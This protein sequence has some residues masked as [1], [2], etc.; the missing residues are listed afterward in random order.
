MA[1][2]D[3]PAAAYLVPVG[4]ATPI[5][6]ALVASLMVAWVLRENQPSAMLDE[7][8]L[9]P[10]AAV[11]DSSPA[12]AEPDDTRPG[13]DQ[14]VDAPPAWLPGDTP[15]TPL[16]FDDFALEPAPPD[17]RWT[18]L[19]T[20][21]AG[22]MPGVSPHAEISYR[23][24]VDGEEVRNWDREFLRQ[25]EGKWRVGDV[26]GVY[27]VA[28]DETGRMA[29]TEMLTV[30]LGTSPLSPGNERPT[31]RPPI[32]WDEI[33]AEDNWRA[34][35]EADT[36]ARNA[37]PTRREEPVDDG[38]GIG[39]GAPGFFVGP[40]FQGDDFGVLI[41]QPRRGITTGPEQRVDGY[42]PGEPRVNGY[43][44]GE[45]RVDGYSPDEPRVRR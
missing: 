3:L 6:S 33:R 4:K 32:D 10:V 28:R 16:G 13:A 41:P 1:T 25:R 11:V 8:V 37:P 7:P 22:L 17:V 30:L 9:D 29:R 19:F 39:V 5:L 35:V 31:P 44:P 42:S 45:P 38:L 40:G 23:W 24:F 43:S 15:P 26:V 27:A 20:A 34:D 21:R 36:R 12:D 18:E 14:W 2:G